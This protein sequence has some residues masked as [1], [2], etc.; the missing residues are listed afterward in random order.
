MQ[1]KKICEKHGQQ[2]NMKFR[3]DFI[4]LTAAACLL[5]GAMP[6]KMTQN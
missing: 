3:H 5:T 6:I 4:S 2:G 1:C